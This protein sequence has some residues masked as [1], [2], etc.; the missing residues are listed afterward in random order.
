M[1]GAIRPQNS[2]GSLRAIDA[3]LTAQ[4]KGYA[5]EELHADLVGIAN[6]ERFEHAPARMSPQG[7]M[8]AARSVIAMAVHHPDA[9]V[10][11]GGMAH[12][13]EMGPYRIQIPMNFRLDEMSYRMALFLERGGRR[14]VPIA[15]S[16]IW[17][18][19]GY[20]DLTA[21]F[22][23]DLSHRHVAVAAGLAE[24]G[25]SGLA[26][27]PEYGARQRYV[28]VITDAELTPSRL[29]E[30]GSVCDNCMLCAEHCMAAALTKE[31][32]G[33]NV[34]KIEDKEYR[35]VKKN[36]WRCAWGEHFGLDL[37]LDI[38]DKV[39]EDVILEAVKRLGT[40]GGAMGSCLRYCLPESRRRFDPEYT[41]APRRKRDVHPG[42]S[43]AGRRLVELARACA[44]R[45]GVDFLVVPPVEQLAAEGVD[46]KAFLPDAESVVSVGLSG[47]MATGEPSP[48]PAPAARNAAWVRDYVLVQ[49]AY[50][51]A[52]LLEQ[53]GHSAVTLTDF[54]ESTLHKLL[55]GT[56]A[57]DGVRT[58]TVVTSAALPPTGLRRPASAPSPARSPQ[59][60]RAR[61][62]R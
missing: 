10:E 37:D 25:Y 43:A 13:Q 24:F 18:Y 34:V 57:G 27:T 23:P 32:D 5:T 19:R 48:G 12:P 50:D 61:I 22:A 41:N 20:K 35:Y 54:P 51:I 39:T 2:E 26:I 14:A 58:R 11:M 31:L 36:L 38:P 7:I 1:A 16:N 33:W 28:T 52:R 30:P 4:V 9:C 6:I 40:R 44:A 42:Q 49:A 29:L 47:A 46:L 59:E 53:H 21:H 8:P 17:R 62:E 15:A 55:D 3:E 45:Q 56:K 60:L